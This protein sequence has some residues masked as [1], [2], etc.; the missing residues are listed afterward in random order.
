MCVPGLYCGRM[1]MKREYGY[2]DL[3]IKHNLSRHPLYGIWHNMIDRCM[4][5]QHASYDGYGG[6]G[7]TVCRRWMDVRNF[8]NDMHPRPP[9]TMLERIDNDKGYYPGNCEWATKDK[10]DNNRRD[11]VRVTIDGVTKPL[12][13]WTKEGKVPLETVRKRLKRGWNPKVALFK[14]P[15]HRTF[16]L[17]LDQVKIIRSDRDTPS[18]VLAEEFGVSR[19]S[20]WS[21]RS[22]E[23]WKGVE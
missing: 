14:P 6:R 21:V 16:K 9:G 13:M 20:I 10:Q 18:R 2:Q 5:P 11:T 3:R 17:T 8:I 23:S 1:V 22:G 15:D 7:I 19:R 12:A 4:N